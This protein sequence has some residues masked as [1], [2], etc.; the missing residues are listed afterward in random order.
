MHNKL[1]CSPPVMLLWPSSQQQ[2]GA[3]LPQNLAVLAY[4]YEGPSCLASRSVCV[5]PYVLPLDII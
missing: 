4:V 5:R 3:V 2:L 1:S